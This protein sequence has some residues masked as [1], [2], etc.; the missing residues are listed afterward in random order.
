[1]RQT[2]EAVF[3]DLRHAVR[4]LRRAVGFTA[5]AVATLTFGIGA[6]TAVFGV[7]SATLLR[8]LSYHEPDDLVVLW[9]EYTSRGWGVVPVSHPNFLSIA[10][11]AAS[12]RGLAGLQ[13]QPLAL[14]GVPEPEML[15][16]VS[17]TPGAFQVLGVAAAIGRTLTAADGEPG[18]ARAVVLSDALWRRGS[19]RMSA[20][21]GGRSP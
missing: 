19:A 9:Q 12:F 13:F 1:V 18:A 20:S 14:T 16:G 7:V 4:S 3:R 6:T 15:A 10:R 21:S 5:A 17:V 8:P 2:V 11:Q